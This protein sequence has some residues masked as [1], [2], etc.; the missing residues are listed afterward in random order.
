MSQIA[1][2]SLAANF[3]TSPTSF[4][5]GNK[6]PRYTDLIPNQNDAYQLHSLIVIDNLKEDKSVK[7]L[8]NKFEGNIVTNGLISIS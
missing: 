4:A 3:W 5:S 2:G 8:N 1:Q 7:L 6:R